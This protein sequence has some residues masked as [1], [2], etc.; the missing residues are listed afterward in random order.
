M[1]NLKQATLLILAMPLIS[2]QGLGQQENPAEQRARELVRLINTG[3]RQ[4]A[5]AYAQRIYAPSFLDRFPLDA[6][7]GFISSKHDR[8]RGL[9][10]H[11]IQ[12]SQ[13]NEITVLLRAKLTDSWEALFV[14]VEPDPPHRI[15][16]IGDR[17]P[18]PPAVA[19]PAKILTD[20]EIVERLDA[21]VRKLAAADVFSGAVLLARNDR[22]LYRK[23]F[24]QANKDFDAR[25]D[26]DTKFNLG[27]MNKMFTAVAIAQLVEQG[28]LSFCDSLS[29]FLPDFLDKKSADKIEIKHLLTHTSGLGSFFNQEFRDGSRA[30]FR[31]VDDMMQ[32][33][34]DEQPAFE[35][36][37]RRQYSNTGFLVLGALIEKVAG[38]TYYDYVRENI[39]RPAG[40]TGT[41]CYDLDQVNPNLAIGYSKEFTD[42]GIRFR[43]N[44]FEHVI[45]GGP[46]GGG[47]STVEDLLRFATALKGNKL[48]GAEY[49]KVLLSPKPELNSPGYGFG[50]DIDT[51]Q[52]KAGHGGGFPGISSNLS[53]YL[54]D[55]Y[56]AVVLSNYSGGAGPVAAKLDEL[57][58]AS[59]PG[60]N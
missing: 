13:P 5:K 57:V 40:M 9:D 47:Y 6:H 42:D 15:I 25:N 29:K 7:L 3:D 17:R 46:A 8:T 19:G 51:A 41:D 37:T 43:N 1:R 30:R 58:Q 44:I 53:M 10:F 2:V 39:A 21:F 32:L 49:V 34:K 38:R 24:G 4:A 48:V 18:T 22:V 20:S 59:R 16:G 36:G 55:G 23:A 31:T 27:S 56:T 52:G 60:G 14:E 28:K 50:F 33:V 11:S 26:I 54:D 45:R 35:A 12:D